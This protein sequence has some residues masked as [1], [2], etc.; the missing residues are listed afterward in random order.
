[1]CHAPHPSL[2][3]FFPWILATVIFAEV[4]AR[5]TLSRLDLVTLDKAPWQQKIIQ[6]SMEDGD[7]IVTAWAAQ[8]RTWTLSAWRQCAGCGWT[9]WIRSHDKVDVGYAEGWRVRWFNS[10]SICCDKTTCKSPWWQIAPGGWHAADFCPNVYFAKILKRCAGYNCQE[11]TIVPTLRI[12]CF[13][14][15]SRYHGITLQ[16]C[17]PQHS[18][19]KCWCQFTTE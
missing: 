15:S 5:F 11:I 7:G 13:H 6:V 14:F 8:H 2:H 18:S 19:V 1:M 4:E 3:H 17:P 9:W 16:K 12:T 10:K